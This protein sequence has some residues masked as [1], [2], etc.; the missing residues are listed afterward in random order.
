MNIRIVIN[1]I[2]FSL[3][4]SY[5]HQ[6]LSAQNP[7]DQ[8][9]RQLNTYF[10][11]MYGLDQKLISGVQY[12]NKYSRSSGNEFLDSD[13]FIRGQLVIKGNEF[14]NVNI[15]YDIYNQRINLQFSY[16]SSA[17][18]TVIIEK[19]KI[20]EFELNDMKFRKYCFPE[21]DTSFFQIIAEGKTSCFYYWYKTLTY[22]TS[23][24]YIYEFSEPRRKSFLLIDSVLYRYIGK[25]TFIKLFPESKSEVRKYIRQNQ[26]KLRYAPD[27]VMEKL[28][29]YCNSL[30]NPEDRE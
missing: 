6:H 30:L 23:A 19:N 12:Y 29:I 4:L 28:I 24:R 26:I 22:Q 2:L 9:I 13:E 20:N 11:D 14:D 3:A 17:T 21:T 10:N 7:D 15:R 8:V 25:Q 18:N 16:G 1:L 5:L 27:P